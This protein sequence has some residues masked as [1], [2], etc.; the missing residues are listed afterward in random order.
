M[1]TNGNTPPYYPVDAFPS[2]IAEAI[3]EVMKKVQAPDALIATS[4]LT[5]MSIAS[6]GSINV[7]LPIGIVCPV[8]LNILIK[9]ESGER[10]TA[11]DR[12][13]CAPI[14]EHDAACI[15]RFQQEEARYKTDHVFWKTVNSTLKSMISSAIKKGEV[16]RVQD[17]R[18][19]LDRSTLSEPAPP[20][21]QR[22]IYQV[23][24]EA[25]LMKALEGEDRSVAIVADEGEVALKGGLMSQHGSRNKG[26]DGCLLV[27]DRVSGVIIARDV[28]IKARGERIYSN[29][30]A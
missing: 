5:A 4:F 3:W 26:W 12:I 17:L 9:A 13:V 21:A 15:E 10:K 27:F 29:R 7:K 30:R 1:N 11:T 18:E 8:S 6:Q 19:E 23:S 16:E 24:T 14:Y 28:L 25:A 2:E 20:R 22:I